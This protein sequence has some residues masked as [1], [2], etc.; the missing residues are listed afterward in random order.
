[1][2]TLHPAL[3]PFGRVLRRHR[4]ARGLSQ[5]D[6]ALA[7]DSSARHL[8]FVE[9]G[10]A[11]PS[12]SMV[13]RLAEA[14]NL[15]LRE[16][17][18]LLVAAGYAAHYPETSLDAAL[19][20]PVRRVLEAFLAMHEPHPALV[21]NR[22]WDALQAN[23]PMAALLEIAGVGAA[24]PP[25]VLWLGLHPN[26]LREHIVDWPAVAQRL[27][28]RAR[29]EPDIDHELLEQ[30]I[31]WPGVGEALRTAS[32]EDD[33]PPLLPLTL[34]LGDATLSWL[35]TVTTFG[36]PQDVTLQELRIESFIPADEATATAARQLL[37]RDVSR[38]TVM[39]TKT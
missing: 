27:V 21:I 30:A 39:F 3:S 1:M 23:R 25:N 29:H 24:A 2:A 19:M 7:A 17:N 38:E 36:T 12:R 28:A 32:E 6:L 9:T 18:E 11:Q 8:S 34:R 33:P 4:V 26:G 20:A 31:A 5:L 37:V 35:T 10:R 16:R 14:L 15:R 13:L 22:R